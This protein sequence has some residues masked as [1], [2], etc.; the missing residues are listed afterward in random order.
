VSSEV[1]DRLTCKHEERANTRVHFH[2]A[3]ASVVQFRGIENGMKKKRK[4]ITQKN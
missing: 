2:R 3:E 1:R 4:R